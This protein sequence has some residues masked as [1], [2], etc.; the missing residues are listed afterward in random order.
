MCCNV[1][2]IHFMALVQYKIQTAGTISLFCTISFSCDTVWKSEKKVLRMQFSV[3]HH[4][5]T[6]S[7]VT[8][9]FKDSSRGK[10]IWQKNVSD[11]KILQISMSVTEN[12]YEIIL[13]W[14][15]PCPHSEHGGLSLQDGLSSGVSRELNRVFG[16]VFTGWR[17][18]QFVIPP[19]VTL[20][21]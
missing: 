17:G 19:H 3:L 9:S 5:C 2:R 18:V 13:E 6:V 1:T 4:F 12:V 8:N 21:G 7:R 15:Y 11:V 20:Q 16:A 14:N 10:H